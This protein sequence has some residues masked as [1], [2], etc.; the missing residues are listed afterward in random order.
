VHWARSYHKGASCALG[1]VRQQLCKS[2]VVESGRTFVSLSPRSVPTTAP[3]HFVH[4]IMF[5]HVVFC[6][7]ICFSSL[8]AAPSPPPSRSPSPPPRSEEPNDAEQPPLPP[9]L[10][11]LYPNGIPMPYSPSSPTASLTP[12]S[13]R[14]VSPP[15]HYVSR[16]T[17]PLIERRPTVRVLPFCPSPPS[18][19]LPWESPRRSHHENIVWAGAERHPAGSRAQM[20]AVTLPIHP[21]FT[22]GELSLDD[23]RQQSSIAGGRARLLTTV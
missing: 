21:Y 16:N 12:P 3:F 18:P 19:P 7:L 8:K 9:L 6:V 10:S 22:N 2:F 13:A 4:F 15:T 23:E 5:F 14:D 11:S 20:P 1:P 17:L